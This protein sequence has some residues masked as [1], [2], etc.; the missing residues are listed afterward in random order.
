MSQR[1]TDIDSNSTPASCDLVP[2]LRNRYFTGKLLTTRDMQAEQ[3]YHAGRLETLGQHVTGEGVVCGLE[4]AV[5]ATEDGLAVSVEPG[6][7]IDACGRPIVVDEPAEVAFYDAESADGDGREDE[8]PEADAISVYLRLDEEATETVPQPGTGDACS[9]D[10]EHNR[11]YEGFAIELGAGEPAGKPIPAVEFPTKAEK[12]A[13]A[14]AAPGEAPLGPLSTPARTYA[15][16]SSDGRFRFDPCGTEGDSQVFLGCFEADGDSGWERQPETVQRHYV[17]TND[18]L[19][20]SILSHATDLGNPHD[21]LTSVD[22]VGHVD[23]NVGFE[24]PSG[25]VESSDGGDGIVNLDVD[26]AGLEDVVKSVHGMAPDGS[27]EVEFASPSGTIDPSQGSDGVVNLDVDLSA[28]GDVGGGIE[29]IEGAGPDAGGDVTFESPSGTIESDDAGT[30]VVN[31]DLSEE[32][33]DEHDVVGEYVRDKVLKYKLRTFYEVAERYAVDNPSDAEQQ[34][35][36]LAREIVR[37]ARDALDE[38][39]FRDE[40]AFALA[41]LYLAVI[42][43]ELFHVVRDG[44][45]ATQEA[46]EDVDRVLKRL[47]DLL[48]E[49]LW[50]WIEGADRPTAAW[51]SLVEPDASPEEFRAFAEDWEGEFDVTALAVI[52][53]QLAETAGWLERPEATITLPGGDERI[54]ARII[55]TAIDRPGRG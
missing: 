52:E 47:E 10:C 9:E 25:T 29:T 30:G 48:P 54:P 38:M 4:T 8:V 17:Y 45:L 3:D 23:G 14:G 24:S 16:N 12:E 35:N 50:D 55:R 31:L 43:A 22:G 34:A 13:I 46:F 6:L 53:D 40:M 36:E 32:L 26:E 37:A 42:E 5:T 27:G 33:R 21:V 2:F 20:S 39:V 19:Y 11:I 15:G 28:L 18:M 41:V 1:H 51:E 44:G 7:A 49:E